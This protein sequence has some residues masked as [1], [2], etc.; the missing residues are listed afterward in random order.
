MEHPL[1][2]R[3]VA[4]KLSVEALAERVDVAKSTISRVETWSADPSFALIRSLII[5]FPGLT[6]NDFMK[7]VVETNE[8]ADA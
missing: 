8:A 7:P 6:A 3:R 5:V 1:R 2:T 4:D